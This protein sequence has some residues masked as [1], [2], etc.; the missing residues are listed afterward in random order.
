MEGVQQGPVL[1]GT[2]FKCG[3]RARSGPSR[4]T[5]HQGRGLSPHGQCLPSCGTRHQGA[6][7]QAPRR[8]SPETSTPGRP[9]WTS[10]GADP[11]AASR[12]CPRQRGSVSRR[13]SS[14]TPTSGRAPSCRQVRSRPPCP[15]QDE[16]G[17]RGGTTAAGLLY[18]LTMVLARRRP[19][20][21][22]QSCQRALPAAP[23]PR[24]SPAPQ[25]AGGGGLGTVVRGERKPEPVL[26]PV[27]GTGTA[28]CRGHGDRGIGG[29]RAQHSVQ[30]DNGSRPATHAA[31]TDVPPPS[32][33]GPPFGPLP[34]PHTGRVEGPTEPSQGMDGDPG[35]TIHTGAGAR[36][37]HN[38]HTRGLPG[39]AQGVGP[40]RTTHR[41]GAGP[42][43]G[44]PT[45]A[46]P[47]G[48]YPAGGHV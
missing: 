48:P 39:P 17:T 32:T 27:A 26:P 18:P 30:M 33:S 36:A 29:H 42:G 4:C 12:C 25:P 46:L 34:R 9:T 15:T 23:A 20:P 13:P 11:K 45:G 8:K 14:H 10:P 47:A 35:H 1:V 3:V 28:S 5:A 40:Y 37:P 41:R 44:A 24:L 16:G 2:S 21:C 38:Y 22:H 19:G 43:T 7:P 6:P 31:A